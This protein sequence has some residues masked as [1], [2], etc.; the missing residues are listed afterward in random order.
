MQSRSG[1][2]AMVP[3]ARDP[4]TALLLHAVAMFVTVSM[5]STSHCVSASGTNPTDPPVSSS[6]SSSTGGSSMGGSSTGA[7]MGGSSTAT[8]MGGSNTG[9]S[10]GESASMGGGMGSS[11]STS[12][13][14]PPPGAC[15]CGAGTTDNIDRPDVVVFNIQAGAPTGSMQ[16]GRGGSVGDAIP[17]TGCT[18]VFVTCYENGDED[19]VFLERTQVSLDSLVTVNTDGATETECVITCTSASTTLVQVVDVHT[20]CSKA[21]YQGQNFGALSVDSFGSGYPSCL[22][23]GLTT[24][25]QR[26]ST[27]TTTRAP[28]PESTTPRDT[29]TLTSMGTVS[30]G[31]PPGGSTATCAGVDLVGDTLTISTNTIGSNLFGWSGCNADDCASV[32]TLVVNNVEVVETSAFNGCT[33]LESVT[34]NGNVQSIGT[35]AFNGC[36]NLATFTAPFAAGATIGN[37]AFRSCTTLEAL[38]LDNVASVGTGACEFCSG[39]TTLQ[40]DATATSGGASIGQNAFKFNSALQTIVLRNINNLGNGAFYNCF[41]VQSITF[42]GHTSLPAIEDNAFAWSSGTGV[43]G[44]GTVTLSNIGN[45]GTSAFSSNKNIRTV[46]ITGMASGSTIGS[47]AFNSCSRLESVSIAT[48]NNNAG[49]NA[50][51]NSAF[52]SCTNLLTFSTTFTDGAVIGN[53]AFK[54]CSS[55]LTL[56]PLRVASIG[57]SACEGCTSLASVMIN[58]VGASGATI[59]QNAF[60]FGSALTNIAVTNVLSIGNGAFYGCTSVRGIVVDGTGAGVTIEPNAFAW[61]SGTATVTYGTATVTNAAAIGSTSFINNKN[62]FKV[63]VIGIECEASIGT[64]AF[65]N[66]NNLATAVLLNIDT[67]GDGAFRNTDITSID[68]SDV[69][70]PF[71]A[72]AFDNTQCEGVHVAGSC[73]TAGDPCTATVGSCNVPGTCI[74]T[75][76]M[77]SAPVSSATSSTSSAMVVGVLVGVVVV[78]AG[79]LMVRRRQAMRYETNDNNGGT[80]TTETNS[81]TPPEVVA[82]EF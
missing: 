25:T 64:S 59:G 23:R 7:S 14:A 70:T 81:Y 34:L 78:V 17:A 56:P 55:L 76:A 67:I 53:D 33:N 28:P 8:S 73:T 4:W 32:R 65:Q 16:D 26:A 52:R 60:K 82:Y 31:T 36:T 42:V 58:G 68:L 80:E 11:P 39:L 41:A 18:E 20:S 1:T 62:L 54:S 19:E 44:T 37:S 6:L 77:G 24:T 40:L 66:C 50:I 49:I 30:P 63:T 13:P 12:G 72:T 5:L 9:A 51:G 38:N 71:V 2:R 48:T 75:E 3:N 47:S 79:V 46:T 21:L 29:G 69:R 35:S 74:G 15:G 61:S 57:T 27:P 43:A 10:M 45:I 22:P